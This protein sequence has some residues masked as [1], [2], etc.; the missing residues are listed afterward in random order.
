MQTKILHG[1]V[2]FKV[3]VIGFGCA[4]IGGYD[5]GP[6]SKKNSLDAINQAW[7]SGINFFDVSDIYGFG[8]AEKVLSEGLGVNCKKA[9]ISTKF[10][11]RKNN[12]GKIV[13]DCSVKWLDEAL[14]ASLKRLNIERIPIYSLHWYDEKTP[15]DALINSLLKYKS[16]GKI[17]RFGVSNFSKELY[18]KFCSLS[19]ENILQL[20]FSL[21][22]TSFTIALQEA[23]QAKNSITMAYD[24]LGR[25]ILTG[26]YKNL[27]SFVGT[28]TRSDH[29]Y[30]KGENFNQNLKILKKLNDIARNHNVSPAVVAIKWVV[31]KEF[32]DVT[33]VGCKT[34]EQV[35]TN[36]KISDLKLSDYDTKTLSEL[37]IYC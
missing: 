34:P 23:Y 3:S 8:N 24:V 36:V 2:N 10:G 15:L 30:F 37:A 6:V 32:I 1:E 19:G 13:R 29:K 27:S 18:L 14:H 7:N 4:A 31:D 28:D 26:K 20:P 11:L 5:Y 35:L 25:G 22:D 17:A 16:Q 33:L 9:I 21:S 12:L